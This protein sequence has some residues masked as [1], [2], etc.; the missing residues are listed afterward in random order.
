MQGAKPHWPLMT[1]PP[2][3]ASPELDNTNTPST[4]EVTRKSPFSQWP[5]KKPLLSVS[6]CLHIFPIFRTMEMQYGYR[7]TIVVNAVP[8]RQGRGCGHGG[9]RVDRT[10]G[11]GQRRLS[12]PPQSG[13]RPRPRALFP[14]TGLPGGQR[15]GHTPGL[16]GQA[17]SMKSN[18]KPRSCNG[19]LTDLLRPPGT[20]GDRAGMVRAAAVGS[21]RR[22]GQTW[23][24]VGRAGP[25]AVP[26]GLNGARSCDVWV[27]RRPWSGRWAL[28][29]AGLGCPGPGFDPCPH[30]AVPPRDGAG[31]D[32]H[33]GWEKAAPLQII[34]AGFGET[35]DP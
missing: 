17:C 14:S 9:R 10:I 5:I 29:A 32:V 22:P 19:A 34:E 23:R 18:W 21:G 35:G 7:W 25:P 28:A 11:S 6:S 12:S 2:S 8:D 31:A 15:C 3:D 13:T 30:I 4:L 26:T 1:S 33:G 20:S 27:R 16:P 24:A